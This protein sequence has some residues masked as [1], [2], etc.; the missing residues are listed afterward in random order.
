[1]RA[2][3][4]ELQKRL[5]QPII[6][7]NR[8]GGGMNIA[9][10]AC[11]EAPNDGYNI[12]ILPNEVLTLNEFTFKSIPYNPE[13]D[14]DPITNCF[15]NTQVLVVS[16]ALGVN[17]LDELAALSKAKPGTLSYSV[18]AIPMQITFENWKKKTG[19]DVIMVPSRGGSDMVTGLL[20]G[21]VP[22]S[23]VGLPNFI[24]HIRSGAVKAIAVDSEA[25]SPLFPDVPTLQELGFPNLAPV[26]FGFVA[27]SGTP[28]DVIEKLHDEIV[29]I[30]SEPSIP[31]EAADRHRHRAGVRHARSTSPTYLKVQRD[32]G[33][34]LISEFG[35]SAAV[36]AA[37]STFNP[38]LRI[39]APHR[40]SSRSMSARYS[41]GLD[42]SGS[43]PS[44]AMRLRTSGVSMPARSARL[45]LVDDRL[46]RAGRR[47][48][49]VV[50][51]GLEARQARLRRGRHVG[52]MARPLLRQHRQRLQ[53]AGL[54]HAHRRRQHVEAERDVAAEQV[55]G[56]RPGAAIGD[57]GDVDAGHRLEQLAGKIA[58]WC[59]AAACRC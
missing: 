54:E 15:I 10:R 41:S 36:V 32:N 31:A 47:Q 23:I 50:Q 53:L 37:Y 42:G 1:M 55:G 7:E 11:A 12:C 35:L 34:K 18:L 13:K 43:P 20:T 22:V 39:S 6:V 17:S 3:G 58:R 30:G 52:Q 49:A 40:A 27:P 45:S 25:R 19:A 29:A 26:Y 51:P 16:S 24:P 57:D 44:A 2:L 9:G 59:R 38:S 14:F 28:K 4:D 56:Q 5:G 33:R 48:Q 8:S 21:T 46:R